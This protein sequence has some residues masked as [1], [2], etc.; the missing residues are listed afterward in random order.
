MLFC[1]QRVDNPALDS[2]DN[3]LALDFIKEDNGMC[4]L[5]NSEKTIDWTETGPAL[6][7]SGWQEN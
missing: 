5:D 6:T 7:I 1:R 3:R 2:L 4:K